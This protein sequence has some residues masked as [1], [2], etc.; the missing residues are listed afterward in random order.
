MNRKTMKIAVNARRL[1][2]VRHGAHPADEVSFFLLSF[3]S[4]V[5]VVWPMHGLSIVKLLN[6]NHNVEGR[7]SSSLRYE[8]TVG[9]ETQTTLC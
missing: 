6:P 5:F 2:D 1:S 3:P 4:N 8:R 9:R 7:P